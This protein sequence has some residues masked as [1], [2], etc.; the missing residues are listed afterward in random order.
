LRRFRHTFWLTSLAHLSLPLGGNARAM[1]GEVT[2]IAAVGAA[3]ERT[4]Q[5]PPSYDLQSI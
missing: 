2:G 5:C 4:N 3:G 1:L